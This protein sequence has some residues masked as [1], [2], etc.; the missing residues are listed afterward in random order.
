MDSKRTKSN[1]Q[2]DVDNLGNNN[3]EK[4]VAKNSKFKEYDEQEFDLPSPNTLKQI[5]ELNVDFDLDL[6][7]NKQSIVEKQ[8]PKTT[9]NRDKSKKPE[10]KKKAEKKPPKEKEKNAEPKKKGKK[11]ANDDKSQVTKIETKKTAKEGAGDDEGPPDKKKG[12]VS[13][14]HVGLKGNMLKVA[15]YL[16][17][18]NRPYSVIN[19]CDNLRGAVK[20]KDLEKIL[21]DLGAQGYLTIKA[22]GATKVFNYN[23][24]KLPLPDIDKVNEKTEEVQTIKGTLDY[25]TEDFKS[26][27]KELSSLKGSQE[28]NKIIG[29]CQNQTKIDLELLE[30]IKENQRNEEDD[31]EE[32]FE[33]LKSQIGTASTEQIKAQKEVKLRKTLL[34]EMVDTM[35]DTMNKKLKDFVKLTQVELEYKPN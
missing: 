21:D 10:K 35:C 20:K 22:F 28:D 11:K 34:K 18:T 13:E 3:D 24:D 4:K 31:N 16:L 27:Q 7:D 32:V 2:E 19:V 29:E 9:K 23:Q 25:K 17:V 30:W 15:E 8:S 14:M 33:Q 1:T 6:S 12:N 5:D 26:Y